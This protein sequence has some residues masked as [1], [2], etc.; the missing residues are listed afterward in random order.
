[1]TSVT[2]DLIA[3]SGDEVIFG[4][5][6]TGLSCARFL[7]REGRRFTVIDTRS[8]PPELATLQREMPEVPVFAGDIPE[9]IVNRGGE[10]V[11]SPG[12]ALEDPVVERAVAAG[13]EVVG[14]IDLFMRAARAPVVGIT[15]SNAKSTVTAL[16]GEM[17]V[18]AGLNV[19]VGGNL[20]TPALDLLADERELYVLE[21]SSFQLE[22][23]GELGLAVATVL[24]VSADHLDRHGTLPRYHQAK[25]RIFRGCH[26]AVINR[27]D[28][29]TLPLLAAAVPVISWRL[30]EPE[31]GG[32]GLRMVD[33]VETL[34]FGFEAL[35]PVTALGIKGRHNVANAL[36]AFALGRAAGLPLDPMV[37]AAR[38]FSG[39]PH[40]CQFVAEA[41]GIRFV[42][43]SKGTNVGA[44]VAA[45]QGLS[46]QGN[47]VLI[48][49]GVGKGQDF[50][51]LRNA[52]QAHCKALVLIGEAA[53]EI[54]T[55]VGDVVIL[56]RAADMIDAVARATGLAAAGDVVLLSPACASFDM[57]SGY[58]A[59]GDAFV[60]AVESQIQ[61]GGA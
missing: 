32:F 48:A 3:S 15:G 19:G 28:P 7:H 30:R 6:A 46:S 14:D 13:A 51:Q 1:M 10:W 49:G 37:A 20:G 8:A 56:Q 18:E 34:C 54:E 40:R 39:L 23:A 38:R 43:D 31:L 12:I 55:A 24:N 2:Q 52:L 5:G 35:L 21:L 58:P 16:L 17:A 29:L 44:T 61:G 42:N 25:H 41:G 45:L 33:G 59:R 22:R 60:A 36:A 26:R 9:A 50:R 53:G 11:V 47:V 57:F 27:D 4:L